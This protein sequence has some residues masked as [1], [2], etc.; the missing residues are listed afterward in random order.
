MKKRR[1]LADVKYNLPSN[2]LESDRESISYVP[3][4][5]ES[6]ILAYIPHKYKK[7]SKKLLQLLSETVVV[8]AVTYDSPDTMFANSQNFGV[9]VEKKLG[10]LAALPG[11]N[12]DRAVY[13]IRDYGHAKFGWI[14]PENPRQDLTVKRDD[15]YDI[16]FGE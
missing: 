10:A 7:L 16:H 9:W 15:I 1:A 13:S 12:V 6:L 2:V 8:A 4:P 3:T 14:N 5:L 11:M